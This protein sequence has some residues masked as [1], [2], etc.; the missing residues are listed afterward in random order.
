MQH[1]AVPPWKLFCSVYVGSS[2]QSALTDITGFTGFT[3][4]NGPNGWLSIA[5]NLQFWLV[6]WPGVGPNLMSRWA[7]APVFLQRGNRGYRPTADSINR[8]PVATYNNDRIRAKLDCLDFTVRRVIG[9]PLDD[10]F[11]N[12]NFSVRQFVMATSSC[13]SFS[14]GQSNFSQ[15]LL[16]ENATRHCPGLRFIFA[17]IALLMVTAPAVGQEP[18]SK[19]TLVAGSE[20]DLSAITGAEWIQGEGPKSFEPG[21]VYMFECWATWCGPCIAL[22]PH[23]NELHNKYYDKGLRVYG[24]NSWEEDKGKAVKFVQKKGKGMS[25]P[26][27]YV[28]KGAAFEKEW[29]NAAGVEAIPYAFVVRN[30]KLLLGTEASRLTNSM[31]EDILSGDEGA[32]RA[33]S[34]IKAA[35]DARDKTEKLIQQIDLARRK[36]NPDTMAGAL[37]K[38]EMLDPG[39]PE[40]SILKLKLLIAKKEWPVAV[41]TFN[42]MPAGN[43]KNS[44]VMMTGMRM[45]GSNGRGY[46]MDFI[47]ALTVPYSEYVA[48]HKKSI[49]PNHFACLSILH[50]KIDDKQAAIAY[51]DTGVEVAKTFGKPSEFRTNAFQRFAKSVKDGTMPTFS[52]LGKWQREAKAEAAKK[53]TSKAG[54]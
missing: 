22:I 49:G 2:R 4:A 9:Y 51:A 17:L 5:E 19:P 48:E 31:I 16:G 35:Y 8:S 13:L 33:A 53:T 15:L 11:M 21:K 28:G 30:G 26:V 18:A 24:M 32:K 52:E 41:T 38:L 25:Y 34:V 20:V 50:W 40:L 39:H 12:H 10:G 54:E 36:K 27:A 44:F 14:N 46:P 37:K 23:V 45:A 29:L 47:K 1:A 6:C 3:V 7:I 43:S 42:E